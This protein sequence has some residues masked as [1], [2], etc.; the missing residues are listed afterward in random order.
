MMADLIAGNTTTTYSL[1]TNSSATSSIDYL[2]DTDWWR[3]YLNSGYQYQVWVEGWY[4]GNGTLLDPYLAIYNAIGAQQLNNDNYSLLTFDSYLTAIPSS[5]GHFYLSAEEAGNNATGSYQITLWQDEIASTATAAAVAVNGS[6]NGHIGWQDDVA[7]WYAVNLTAGFTYQFDLVG[8][9][10]DGASS[11]LTLVDPWLT[12]HSVAGTILIFD[13]D[14]GLGL[15]SRIFY[16][17]STSGTYYLDVEESGTNASGIYQLFVNSSPLSGTLTLGTSE[18]G[19]VDFAGEVDLYGITLTAGTTYL[20][21]LAGA[22]LI[23]PFLEIIGSNLETVAFDDDSGYS[24]NSSIIYMPATTGNYYLAARESGNN[25]TG[26]YSIYVSEMPTVSISGVTVNET[27]SGQFNATFT[28][29]L[30]NAIHRNVVIDF[31]TQDSTARQGSDYVAQSGQLTIPAGE[32]SSTITVPILGDTSFEPTE[33]FYV[34][35]ANPQGAILSGGGKALA[36]ITDNDNPYIEFFPTDELTTFQWY[37]FDDTGINV[38][39]IWDEYSGVGVKVAVFDQGIDPLHPDLNGNLLTDL[40]V[41]ASTLTAGGAPLLATDK[42]GT[43]VAGVIAAERDGDGIVGVAHAADLV[44]IY[45]P[46]A[47][48][49][50]ASQIASAYS[51]AV[52]ADVLNDSWGFANGFAS[53]TTWAFYDNFQSATFSA[54]GAALANLAANGRN[55]LGTVVVQSAGNSFSVGDDTNLHNFQNSQYIITVAATDYDGD[56]T[57]YSSPGASILIAAPGGGGSD[58]IDLSNILTTDRIDSAGYGPSNYYTITGTSFS[59][60]IISGVVALMLEANPKLGYRDVQE[61]LA[62]SARMTSTADNDWQY[63]GASNWNGGGLHYDALEHNLGF[64]LV[65]AHAAVR[66]AE[67][68]SASSHTFANRQQ[69]SVSH[70]PGIVIPDNTGS[71]AFDS[72]YVD[73]TIDV[74]RV[75][76]TLNVTHPFIGDLSV[77]L[78]SPSGTTSFMLWRPQQNALS[79]YGTGQNNI[80]FTFDT[81][82]NWGESSIGTWGLGI[83]DNA[84]GDIGTFDSWSLNLIGKPESSDDTYI[85]TDE[86][87]S[88]ANLSGRNQLTDTTGND[89]LNAAAVTFDNTINLNTGSTSTIADASLQITTATIIENAIGGDGNDTIIGN[90]FDNTLRGMH[91]ND[92]LTGGD[93]YDTFAFSAFGNEIDT[94]TDFSNGD[95]IQIAGANFTNL[96]TAGDGVTIAENQVRLVTAGEITTAYIGLN[97]APG[98]ELT[99]K[100]AGIFLPE[101][102]WAYGEYITYAHAPTVANPIPDQSATEDQAFSY[103]I[104][105]NTFLDVDNGDSITFT[106]LTGSGDHSPPWLQFN[107][108]TRTLNGTPG[109]DNVDYLDIRITATD[110]TNAATSDIFRINY[111]NVNDLPTGA[112]SITGSTVQGLVL[113]ASNTL[114]DNDGLGTINYQWQADGINITGATLNA[115]LLTEA[116]VGKTITV[117]ASYV[118][119]HSTAESVSSLATDPITWPTQGSG[120]NDVL[121]ANI[122]SDT[123]IGGGG[124]D[125]Y[126]VFAKT[127]VVIELPN[128]GTD[129]VR[130]GLSWT[131]AANLENLTLLGSKKFSAIG[132][133]LNNTL[134]GNEAANVLNGGAGTDTLN[135]GAGN[136]VYVVD[137]DNDSIQETQT[138]STEIDGVR[139]FVDWTLGDNLENLTLLGTRNLDGNGNGLNNRLTGNGGANILSGGNGND[140]LNGASGNDTLTGGTGADTFAFTTPLNALRNI[141]NVTDFSSGTDKIQLSPAIFREIGFTGAP[142]TEAFFHA[143]SAAQDAD[144]R[145]L[146]DQSNGELYY[147]ADGNGALAAVQFA[148]LSSLPTLLYSDILTA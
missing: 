147:D 48:N 106:A 138:S 142:S 84:Y 96:V 122:A 127:N 81:V 98:A 53:G 68:W 143:G 112:V 87:A 3:V 66:L 79:A 110:R 2:G 74:E 92:T 72:V 21:D 19:G 125:I 132:N 22:S 33:L 115:Y 23:D 63:N 116:E 55:G 71:S 7:D 8:S 15:N 91:G 108:A 43:A 44:S 26:T 128:E 61:I 146:Y 113:S 51:Y 85:Y 4:S 76:V 30:S 59:A 77:L 140:T 45:S 27:D 67:T 69:V 102:L 95:L 38:F 99:I 103:V 114:A 117:I 29:G 105:S 121:T 17:P 1:P 83:F 104:P 131:L 126:I 50:L 111:I 141:D 93:G 120:G 20:F 80:N 24:L 36:F 135:G 130:A 82:L 34:N 56:V 109:N 89:T 129:T 62:Y 41:R 57:S 88:V 119:E 13:D 9:S 10:A 70:S 11:G 94:I 40:G 75:E 18:Y 86:Y 137:S 42:H 16:T 25:A 58:E 5:S 97:E 90:A 78:I 49:G 139:S 64:G 133:N 37:L 144:D 145:V 136:D 118:D 123:L 28:A 52:I 39:P 12:L 60:P 46:L 54:A 14:S 148:V 73:Q 32:T 107:A 65:D 100:L 47:L 35:L 101:Q 31:S 6:V 124:D 134:T